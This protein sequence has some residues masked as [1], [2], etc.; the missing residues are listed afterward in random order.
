MHNLRF[1]GAAGGAGAGSGTGAGQS[2]GAAV[3]CKFAAS[4][5]V[6]TC[7]LVDV[8]TPGEAGTELTSTVGNNWVALDSSEMLLGKCNKK[9]RER[10]ILKYLANRRQFI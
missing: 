6:V 3:D 7:G 8:S 2:E 10:M 1:T 5:S 4:I 9:Q